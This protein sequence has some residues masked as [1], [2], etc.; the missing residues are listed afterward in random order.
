MQ[1]ELVKPTR[2]LIMAMAGG[3]R[4]EVLALGEVYY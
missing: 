4:V 3:A 1:S 2:L